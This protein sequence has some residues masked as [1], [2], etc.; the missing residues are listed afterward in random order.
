[1]SFW[2]RARNSVLVRCFV[3]ESEYRSPL[4]ENLGTTGG[5]QNLCTGTGFV[6]VVLDTRRRVNVHVH[7]EESSSTGLH[8]PVVH[9]WVG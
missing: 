3:Q 6:D 9:I 4:F 2:T 7:A 5:S 1:M 8:I